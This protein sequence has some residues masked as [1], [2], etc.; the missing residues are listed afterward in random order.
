MRTRNLVM[1]GV[2]C[3]S[4]RPTTGPLSRR[5]MHYHVTVRLN[6]LK[7]HLQ[8]A[9]IELTEWQTMMRSVRRADGSGQAVVVH[10]SIALSGPDILRGGC[11]AKQPQTEHVRRKHAHAMDPCR[12]N[13]YIY[14]HTF[15]IYVFVYKF[16]DA[17]VYICI[18]IDTPIRIYK[19]IY[20]FKYVY[21][22]T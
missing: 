12:I 6:R 21:I 1:L 2:P 7:V 10:R 17:C 16:R 8:R 11:F 20:I 14:T 5:P 3:G 9:H 19:Y 13:I 18:Y 22:C 4:L 15:T